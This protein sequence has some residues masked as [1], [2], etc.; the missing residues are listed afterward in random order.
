MSPET[1]KGYSSR[2]RGGDRMMDRRTWLMSSFSLLT[3]PLVAAAQSPAKVFRI[4]LLGGSSPTSPEA[5]RVWAGLLQGLRELG[6]VEGQNMVIEGRYYGDSIERLPALA[7]ELV[8]LRVDVIVAGAPPAPEAAKAATTR[9]RGGPRSARPARD[10]C[11]SQRR[12]TG[13]EEGNQ[14]HPHRRGRQPRWGQSGTVREPR[15]TWRER[16]GTREPSTRP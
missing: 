3:T 10:R 2:H 12:R 6:Y 15:P 16:H 4:G 1:S 7:A 9:A 11:G 5:S 13:G 14:H 8:R